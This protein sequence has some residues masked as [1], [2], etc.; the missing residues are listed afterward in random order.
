MKPKPSPIQVKKGEMDA[1]KRSIAN[2]H[3][4]YFRGDIA[5]IDDAWRSML[6][7]ADVGPDNRPVKQTRRRTT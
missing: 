2:L 6:R 5:E 1:L 7:I 4:S 3:A